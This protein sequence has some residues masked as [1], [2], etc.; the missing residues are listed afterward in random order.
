[1]TSPQSD[2]ARKRSA[3]T[4]IELLVVI[5]IIAILIG[6]LLPAVQKVREAAARIKCANNLKQMGLAF[7]NSHE[8]FGKLPP[9]IANNLNICCSGTWQM[10]ILPFVEQ[11]PLWKTYQNFGGPKGSVPSYEQGVNLIV[12]STRLPTFT[13]PSDFPST[14]K[15]RTS[16]GQTYNI[17]NHNYLVNVGNI[18]YAQGKDG[19]LPDQPAGLKFLGAPFART[20]QFRLTDITDGTSTTLMG[21]EVKQGQGGDCR[22]LTWWGEGSGFTTYRTPNHPGPDYISGGACVPTSQ[23]AQN[24]DC[25]Q[26]TTP[27]FNVFTARSRHTGGVNVVHCDGSTRFVRDTVAWNVWQ[28][29]GTSQGNEVVGD[30]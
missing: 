18:D 26:F 4:L 10:A 11:D 8:T 25:K 13:C 20:A 24:S 30:Y 19:A 28:A 3:F 7:H 16:N 23:N 27:N 14:P 22:G 21:A 2:P 1:M 12:T 5:A 6:L 9:Q 17:T 29:L 15:T